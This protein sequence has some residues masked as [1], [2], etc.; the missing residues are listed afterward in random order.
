MYYEYGDY[1]HVFFQLCSL[2]L[3][4]II[5]IFDGVRPE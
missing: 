3:K 4:F 1:T 5:D 2:A